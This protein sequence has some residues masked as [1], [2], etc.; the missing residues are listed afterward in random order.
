MILYWN[1][2]YWIRFVIWSLSDTVVGKIEWKT[3]RRK[4]K[5]QL[6]E[7]WRDENKNS[8]DIH[9]FFFDSFKV[10]SNFSYFLKSVNTYSFFI[11]NTQQH[12]NRNQERKVT[13]IQ[14]FWKV[15][16]LAFT[17]NLFCRLD[18]EYSILY[19]MIFSQTFEMDSSSSS[20]LVFSI[21]SFFE[22]MMWMYHTIKSIIKVPSTVPNKYINPSIY[23]SLLSIEGKHHQYQY[24]YGMVVAS[25]MCR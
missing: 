22:W 1:V 8:F 7:T 10:N 17:I 25:F 12:D 5:Y 11:S 19:F 24:R 4:E 23:W 13:S 15:T 18:G 6:N 20:V 2:L 14:V 9:F 21:K 16:H 3:K